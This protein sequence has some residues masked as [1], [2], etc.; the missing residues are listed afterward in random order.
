MFGKYEARLLN[1]NPSVGQYVSVTAFDYGSAKLNIQSLES[2]IGSPSCTEFAIPI[3]SADV[4]Q[5]DKLGVSVFPNPYKISFEG[6]T[7]K[8]TTYFDEGFEAPE[9]KSVGGNLDEQDR[10][11]WFVN[12]PSRA[13]IR[14]FTLD[15][16]LVRQIDHIDPAVVQEGDAKAPTTDYSSR[17]YWD[18]ITRNTQAAVSGIYIYR[19]DSELGSQVGKLVIIK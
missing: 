19:V 4:V 2:K 15:G 8:Q 9:K 12:L 14:I 18:L 5:R 10:R 16:D 3:Y 6:S 13:T 7:G 17:A 11:I 1:M